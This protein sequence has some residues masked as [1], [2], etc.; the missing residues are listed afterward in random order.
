MIL[1]IMLC[2]SQI[3][4]LASPRYKREEV[5]LLLAAFQ[6]EVLFVLPFS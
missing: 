1:L 4:E 3:F 2:R 6:P 5:Q